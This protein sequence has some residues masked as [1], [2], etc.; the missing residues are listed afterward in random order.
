MHTI[1]EKKNP[2]KTY[3]VYEIDLEDSHGAE[4]T[5]QIGK[6]SDIALVD[7]GA[8]CSCM[9]EES[10]HL[11]NIAPLRAM[12][13][14]NVKTTSGTNLEPLR[15]VECNFKLGTTTYVQPFIVCRK[16]TRNFILGRDFLRANRLHIGWS[17]EGRFRVQSRKE[18]LIEAISIE[19]QPVVTMKKNI[20]VPPRTLVVVEMQTVIPNL[21]GVG[22]YDFMPTE[23]YANQ[24][25]NLVLVPVAYYTTT[26]G[27][28]QIL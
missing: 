24:E 9:S 22:Y 23:R 16:L 5:L 14:I 1:E 8:Y 20:T 11:H 4:V 13:N 17:K 27:K 28:Q 7:T 3:K 10:Y 19:T 2:R 12:C 6:N 18:V 21:E 25:V 26:A 15:I